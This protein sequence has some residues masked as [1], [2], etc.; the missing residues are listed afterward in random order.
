VLP[1]LLDLT[2]LEAPT[3]RN[4]RPL[5]PIEGTSFAGVLERPE[6]PSQHGEQY[7]EM[8]GH[9]GL[10]REGW[11]VVT[12]HL[13][14]TKFSED[15]WE[16]YHLLTD[17]T[18]TAD[19][20]ARHPEKVAELVEAWERA[21]WANQVFPLNEGSGLMSLLRPPTEAV[22]G[23]PVTILPGTPTLER[24]RSAKLIEQRAFTLTIRLGHRSG[25]EGVLVAHGDQ[26][27]G[28]L[29]YVE[30]GELHYF[31]HAFGEARA[32]RGGPLPA[33]DGEIVLEATAPGQNRWNLRLR[34]GGAEVARGDGFPMFS[35]LT[36]FQG[37]DVG[38][39]RRSPVSWELSE[40]HGPFPYTGALGSVTYTPGELAP[41][42]GPQ[43]LQQLREVGLRFE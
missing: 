43:L 18:E 3:Q 20:A 8:N 5:K 13:P 9:R 7:F 1:T 39:D 15:R 29:L 21:A 30:A 11:E 24:Y 10:Y 42:R 37:I 22:F 17:P 27:G 33:G 38:I 14:R 16:L 32:L 31:H 40:R 12:L 2:G 28:Y 6:A 35:H 34:V 41:D 23:E 4:G 19:L 26:A 25:D 36:P